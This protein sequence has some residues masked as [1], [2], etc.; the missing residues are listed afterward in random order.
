[1][2]LALSLPK[3]RAGSLRM[4]SLVLNRNVAAEA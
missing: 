3:F 2:P 4:E 1:M